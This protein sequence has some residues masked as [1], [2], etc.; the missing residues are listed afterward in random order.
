MVPVNN[1]F[2]TGGVPVK[3]KYLTGTVPVNNLLLSILASLIYSI[4]G[5]QSTNVREHSPKL[6][7]LLLAELRSAEDEDRF[8]SARFTHHLL[9]SCIR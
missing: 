5:I 2:L 6:R 3:K 9:T 1:E 8:Q 4:Q 7:S